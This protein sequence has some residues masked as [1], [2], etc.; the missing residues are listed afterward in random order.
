MTKK[1]VLCIDDSVDD[2]EII[3]IYLGNAGFDV[4]TIDNAADGLRLA[5]SG[6][7]ALCIIDVR[8]PDLSGVD[9]TRK[10]REFDQKTPIL[11]HSAN[12]FKEDIQA[13]MDAGAQAYMT[14]PSL[15]R[16][17]TDD[18]RTLIVSAESEMNP[19]E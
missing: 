14:K 12:A 5:L 19:S 15:P 16:D 1:R 13:G 17:V 3:S 6:D 4:T 18:V 10:I 9:L 8:L 11:I 2:C 7:F